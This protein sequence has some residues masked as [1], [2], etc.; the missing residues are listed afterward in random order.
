MRKQNS[1][2]GEI[3]EYSVMRDYVYVRSPLNPYTLMFVAVRTELHPSGGSFLVWHRKRCFRI[4]TILIPLVLILTG[5]V[6][7][8]HFSNLARIATEPH[9]QFLPYKNSLVMCDDGSVQTLCYTSCSQRKTSE[10]CYVQA[11][12]PDLDFFLSLHPSC[13]E[14]P[15]SYSASVCTDLGS[16]YSATQSCADKI[17]F[18]QDTFWIVLAERSSVRESE[19][20]EGYYS[21]TAGILYV[22]SMSCFFIGS[23]LVFI[24]KHILIAYGC[25]TGSRGFMDPFFD[26]RVLREIAQKQVSEKQRVLFTCINILI[27]V[28]FISSIVIIIFA[29]LLC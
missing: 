14:S 22:V 24:R 13:R 2:H 20:D 10:V 12:R 27:L 1:L 7:N 17:L 28:L 29:M 16:P 5:L 21:I 18:G 15:L 19:A 23:A 11:E 9:E 26:H 6:V 8:W 25:P 3:T 4:N